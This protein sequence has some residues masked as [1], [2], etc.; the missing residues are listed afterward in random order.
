MKDFAKRLREIR[1]SK[2][3]TQGD[4][5]KAV[6][7]SV[8]AIGMYEQDRREPNSEVIEALAKALNVSP[9]YLHGWSV[10]IPK[11]FVQTLP[12]TDE[13]DEAVAEIVKASLNLKETSRERLLHYAKFLLSEEENKK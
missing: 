7:I 3:M 13:D 12:W 1:K 5:A 4:L 9:A 11:E 6:G 8:S 10:T 2:G